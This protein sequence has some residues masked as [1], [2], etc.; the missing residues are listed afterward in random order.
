MV[1]LQVL[2]QDEHFAAVFKPSGM[3]VHYNQFDRHS[4]VAVQTLRRQLG[5][6]VHP[7]HR[8]DRATSGVLMFALSLDAARALSGVFER[9]E[10]EKRYL[11][12][13]R[14]HLFQPQQ[15]DRAIVHH[16][17]KQ[18][19]SAQTVVMPLAIATVPV[20]VG[21]YP[22]AR[23]SLVSAH[24]LTG[25]RHQLRRHLRGINHPIIG[26]TRLGDTAHNVFFREQ[27]QSH[28]LLL[29]AVSID[30]IHPFTQ[31]RMAVKSPVDSEFLRLS[32]FLEWQR[33]D[34]IEPSLPFKTPPDDDLRPFLH[35]NKSLE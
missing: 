26:D 31:H 13:V 25:R 15:I 8:L 5:V 24:P 10:V 11:A 4:P 18:T 19:Q 33:V 21:R 6:K 2:F 17:T 16:E 35:A 22:E 27:F 29:T 20:P 14:G 28:R 9:G 23:Y 34:C 7:V 32:E 12:L 3:M 30:F 1:T